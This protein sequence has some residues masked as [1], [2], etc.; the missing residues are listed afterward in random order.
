LRKAYHKNYKGTTTVLQERI[1]DP[2]LLFIT[3]TS[4]F[5]RS[6]I[7]NRLKYK[8]DLVAES[9]GYTKGSGTFH[10][11]QELYTEM[12]SFLKRRNIDINT[13]FGYGPSRK[14]RLI[15]QAFSL[16]DLKTYHYHN[17]E[18]GVRPIYYQRQL[19]DMTEFWKER[20]A[21]PRMNR[22]TSWKNFD[23][24]QFLISTKRNVTRWSNK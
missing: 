15:D 17:I 5:G 14:V 4:A 24:K 8:E 7:Y 21:I 11:S 23:A 16:L 12:Q 6:S 9:L 18:K 2:H 19:N 13:T 20:W 3:T 10:I 1:I 22:D